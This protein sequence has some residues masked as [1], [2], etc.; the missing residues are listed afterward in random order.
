MERIRVTV[1]NEFIHERQNAAVRVIY[2][3]GIHETIAAALREHP[4]LEVC[5][6]TLS[7]AQQG[8][9]SETLESTDVLIYWGH[10]AHDQV[11]DEMV[12]RVQRRVLDGMGLVV[13]HSGH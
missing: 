11:L 3:E 8:L 5:T 12:D 4:G 10:A 1:W 6:R 2:P 7:D 9:G 13:L